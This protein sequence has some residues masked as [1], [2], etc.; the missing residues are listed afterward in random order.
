MYKFVLLTQ[1]FGW[2]STHWAISNAVWPNRHL[3]RLHHFS[4]P[5]QRTHTSTSFWKSDTTAHFVRIPKSLFSLAGH[6]SLEWPNQFI[7]N[8][9]TPLQTFNSQLKL[10]LSSSHTCTQCRI[11]DWNI[12]CLVQRYLKQPI[13]WSPTKS[14]DAELL[15][16]TVSFMLVDT[17][18]AL[19]KKTFRQ[20][21][22][23][24]LPSHV[25]NTCKS[26]SSMIFMQV[27][28][29]F[30]WFWSVIGSLIM[31]ECWKSYL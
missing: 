12:C 17:L 26:K 23:K 2:Q 19:L 30:K 18:K 3:T 7:K 9:F 20:R 22:N 13:Y 5:V 8:P 11:L 1:E 16:Q 6:S 25:L 27:F 31:L 29:M 15:E 28:N 21:A 10:F 24:T 14:I 4:K